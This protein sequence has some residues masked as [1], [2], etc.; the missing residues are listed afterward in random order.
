MKYP[1][2]ARTDEKN[3]MWRGDL[4]KYRALHTWVR[5]KLGKPNKCTNCDVTQEIGFPIFWANKSWLYKRD[6]NDWIALCAYCH[7]HYDHD[8]KLPDFK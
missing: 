5:R 4:V 7:Y 1:G 3:G 2:K 6:L 8:K